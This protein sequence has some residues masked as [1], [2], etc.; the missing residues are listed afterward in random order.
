MSVLPSDSPGSKDPSSESGSRW[1][2]SA[3]LNRGRRVT[4]IP[5]SRSRREEL[6]TTLW[7]VP[8]LM[9][10]LATRGVQLSELTTHHATLE[11]VFMSLTG[12]HLRD[13]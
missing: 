1:L 7:A 9:T 10:L 12:R 8:A 13:E 6:R 4:P 3:A 5:L 11:D 2:L